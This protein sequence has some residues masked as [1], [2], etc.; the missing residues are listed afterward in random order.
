[1]WVAAAAD[2]YCAAACSSLRTRSGRL[3]R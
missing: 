2:E 3:I 1:M